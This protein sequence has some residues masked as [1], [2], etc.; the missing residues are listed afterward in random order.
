MAGDDAFGQLV[1]DRVMAMDLPD[2]EVASLGAQPYAL[3]HHLEAGRQGLVI[4]DASQATRQVP[5]GQ[6]LDIDFNR[7]DELQLIH[8][9]ALSTHG[10]SVAN[11]L[12]LAS[13]LDIL[14]PWVRL[15]SATIEHFEIGCSPTLVTQ[16]LVEPAALC[17]AGM[18][19][20]WISECRRPR[21]A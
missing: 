20:Q 4:V 7:A 10:L 21:H 16:S 15:V 14:P 9:I 2:V 19:Q 11:E 18:V 12:E 3:V 1:G 6:L 5:A 13:K 8:D 17:V